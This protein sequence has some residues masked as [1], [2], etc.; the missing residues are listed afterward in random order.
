MK[1]DITVFNYSRFFAFKRELW[2]IFILMR[3]LMQKCFIQYNFM[4]NARILQINTNT[5]TLL[6]L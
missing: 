6:I 3:L 1:C 2:E 4:Q 5:K